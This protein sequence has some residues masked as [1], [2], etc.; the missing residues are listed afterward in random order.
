MTG[1]GLLFRQLHHPAAVDT[2]VG[3][4]DARRVHDDHLG[5]ALPPDAPIIH[6]LSQ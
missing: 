6:V 2:V 3:P 1:L 4:I 5:V